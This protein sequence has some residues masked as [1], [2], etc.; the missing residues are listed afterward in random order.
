M[1]HVPENNAWYPEQYGELVDAAIKERAVAAKTMTVVDDF[2]GHRLSFPILTE[3]PEAGWY[4]PGSEIALDDAGLSE[5]TVEMKAVKGLTKLSNESVQDSSPALAAVIGQALSRKIT[6]QIDAAL[7]APTAPANGAEG[8]ATYPGV[9]TLSV[10]GGL[11]TVANAD[12][13]IEGRYD[14]LNAADA[15]LTH[16]VVAPDVAKHL[17]TAKVADGDNRHLI[18]HNAEGD[19]VIDGLP[20]LVSRHVAPGEAWG[21]DKR[22][23]FFCLRQ[24]TTVE[25]SRNAAFTSDS[26]MIRGVARL[27]FAVPQPAGVVHI[28]ADAAA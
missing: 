18:E 15:H 3:D 8:L 2:N 28:V 22:Q 24:G 16:W 25:M 12:V 13:F 7:F 1:V 14:A 10:T 4:A 26:T 23:V 9:T 17:A 19:L 5:L 27:N 6:D 20:A 11:T 21:L